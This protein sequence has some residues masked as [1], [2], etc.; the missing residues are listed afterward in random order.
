[1]NIAAVRTESANDDSRPGLQAFVARNLTSRMKDAATDYVGAQQLAFVLVV[2][3]ARAAWRGKDS[4][5]G[6][7]QK[8][9]QRRADRELAL[10]VI[11][12]GEPIFVGHTWTDLLQCLGCTAEGI[13]AGLTRWQQQEDGKGDRLARR[14]AEILEMLAV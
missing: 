13:A 11:E 3:L 9:L 5:E 8:Q 4:V 1:M 6:N 7:G 14:Q 10:R 12:A 2:A